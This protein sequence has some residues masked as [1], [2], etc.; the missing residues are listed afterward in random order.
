MNHLLSANMRPCTATVK[1][2]GHVAQVGAGRMPQRQGPGN[3]RRRSRRKKVWVSDRNRR[4]GKGSREH[5]VRLIMMAIF[6][7][8][9]DLKKV[10]LVLIFLSPSCLTWA[11]SLIIIFSGPHCRWSIKTESY[12]THSQPVSLY[13]DGVILSGKR[14]GGDWRKDIVRKKQSHAVQSQAVAVGIYSTWL[15]AFLI[16]LHR[17]RNGKCTVSHFRRKRG[18]ETRKKEDGRGNSVW[19]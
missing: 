17:K 10:F 8:S 18:K 1:R 4:H 11:V 5:T 14:G 15:W 2:V 9:H 3:C 7:I 19:C 13:F 16:K 12:H 6:T